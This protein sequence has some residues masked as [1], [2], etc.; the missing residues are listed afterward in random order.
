MIGTVLAWA[1]VVVAADWA[2]RR[3]LR[4]IGDRWAAAI[5][6]RITGEEYRP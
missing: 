4:P 6:R 3:W 5:Y 2:G 1:V